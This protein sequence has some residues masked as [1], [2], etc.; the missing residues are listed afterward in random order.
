MKK[1][2]LKRVWNRIKKIITLGCYLRYSIITS[3]PLSLEP[4]EIMIEQ[5]NNQMQRKFSPPYASELTIKSDKIILT[6]R[7]LN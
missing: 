6:D 5:S 1:K 2:K 7:Q 4:P 3:W